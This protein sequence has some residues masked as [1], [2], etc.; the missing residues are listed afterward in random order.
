MA[1]ARCTGLCFER[2]MSWIDPS[3][4][5]GRNSN[6]PKVAPIPAFSEMPSALPPGG[7]ARKRAILPWTTIVSVW[8]GSMGGSQSTVP[9]KATSGARLLEMAAKLS[10][11]AP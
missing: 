4:G 8:H 1:L 3:L 6:S 2:M 7:E 9:S 11:D 5:A 10:I